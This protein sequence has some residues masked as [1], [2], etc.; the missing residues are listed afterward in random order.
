MKLLPRKATPPEVTELDWAMLG[1]GVRQPGL[2]SAAGVGSSKFLKEMSLRDVR[3]DPKSVHG[4]AQ[5]TNLEYLLLLNVD[6]LVWSFRKLAGL[7]TPGRPYGGWEEPTGQL[8][9]H[10]VG[11]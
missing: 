7:P 5:Q 10:F 11:N 8:R 3:I 1:R 4:R 6:R 9:G 2:T